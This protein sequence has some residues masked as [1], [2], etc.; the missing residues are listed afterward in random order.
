MMQ[1]AVLNVFRV[2][3]YAEDSPK[4]ASDFIEYATHGAESG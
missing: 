1:A 4:H 3:G 2:I